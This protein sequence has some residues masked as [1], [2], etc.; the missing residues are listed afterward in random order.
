MKIDVSEWGALSKDT[1]LK[2]IRLAILENQNKNPSFAKSKQKA[3][4]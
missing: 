4:Y 1:K 2:L 3:M